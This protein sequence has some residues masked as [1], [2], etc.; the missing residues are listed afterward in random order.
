MSRVRSGDDFI[1]KTQI[2][3]EDR[4]FDQTWQDMGKENENDDES[5]GKLRLATK[6]LERR[7]ASPSQSTCR[8][9]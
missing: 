6:P 4:W 3:L 7:S 1:G 5:K 9:W 2:D 8:V